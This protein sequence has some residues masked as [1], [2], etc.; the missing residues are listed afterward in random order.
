[1][2]SNCHKIVR[3]ITT[4]T[5]RK[6]PYITIQDCCDDK[7]SFRLTKFSSSVYYLCLDLRPKLRDVHVFSLLIHTKNRTKR[8]LVHPISLVAPPTCLIV[9]RIVF[10]NWMV[11]V[12]PLRKNLYLKNLIGIDQRII[13]DTRYTVSRVNIVVYRF[14][15]QTLVPRHSLCLCSKWF[16]IKMTRLFCINYPL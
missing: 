4:F 7:V 16:S 10:Y 8:S 15:F 2:D 1:M 13:V 9:W 12:I 5:N 3:T 6:I 14:L 11:D